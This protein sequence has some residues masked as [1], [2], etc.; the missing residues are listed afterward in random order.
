MESRHGMRF[1]D[2]TTPPHIFTLIL[3]SGT[4]AMAMNMFLPSLPGMAEYFGTEYRLMQLS[5]ALFLA[6]NAAL[7][8]FIGPISDRYGR[9]PVL[10]WSFVIFLLATLG[11]IF[12]PNVQI[13]LILR[14]VQAVIIAALVLSR[15]V[16]RDLYE[17][18]QA[19]SALG[20]V[21]MGMAVV[22]MITPAIGG[23]LDEAFGWQATFWAFIV[24]GGSALWL[25]WIDLGETNTNKSGG[26]RKQVADYPELFMSPRFWGYALAAAFSASVFFAY[27]GGAPF[28]GSV[29]FELSP[30][31][32]GILFGAP[33]LGYILGNFI[34]GRYS[35]RFGINR[36]IIAGA[37]ICS[38]GVMISLSVFHAGFGSSWSFFGL[39]TLVGL[40]NGM[41]LP[42][43]IAGTLS[44][45]PHLAGTA[46][47]LGGALM[48]GGGAAFSAI[49]GFMLGPGTGPYPLLWIQLAVSFLSI[50][51]ILL[52]I[53]RERRL[54]VA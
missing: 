38:A 17:Q 53:V 28:V 21:T 46:S 51:A 36:M 40:G 15:A 23:W 20:Y 50:M 34:S 19:A 33:A 4:S 14:M 22:P 54:G 10:I 44:V 18:N 31:A 35:V 41:V 39:M 37:S 3:M 27:M 25:V 45:R 2:R 26:F 7:Q 24:I 43:A 30:T 47:G 42:N 32:L 12:A 29:V 13:F 6:M 9:R 52:V 1:L 8:L 49:A 5:V 16:V 48:I 11:C